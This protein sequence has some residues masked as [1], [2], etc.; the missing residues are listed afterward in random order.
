MYSG[1]AQAGL[2]NTF[3][4]E[5]LRGK[6]NGEGRKATVVVSLGFDR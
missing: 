3:A 6:T 1:R 5:L 2:G 4:G